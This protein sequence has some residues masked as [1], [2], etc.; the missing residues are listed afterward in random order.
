MISHVLL[1]CRF[2]KQCCLLTPLPI[3]DR[4]D[5]FSD[6]LSHLLRFQSK[7][8]ADL[9][10]MVCCSILLHRNDIIWKNGRTQ[11]IFSIGRVWSYTIGVQLKVQFKATVNGWGQQPHSHCEKRWQKPIEGWMKLNVDAAIS[12]HSR[13]VGFGCVLRGHRGDFVAAC[14]SSQ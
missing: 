7:E 1:Q 2:A 11:G 12:L 6:W 14:A 3:S 5:V 9:T 8:L 4:A 10:I 13:V